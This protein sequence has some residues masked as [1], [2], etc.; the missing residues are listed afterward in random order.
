MLFFVNAGEYNFYYGWSLFFP[1]RTQNFE[2]H[3][4]IVL[5]SEEMNKFSKI[6]IWDKF[7]TME[8]FL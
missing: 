4:F 7:A 2:N 1:L 5:I 8:E 6:L 3:N